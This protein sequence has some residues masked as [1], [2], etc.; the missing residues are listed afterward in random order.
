[1]AKT[2]VTKRETRK[3]ELAEQSVVETTE[4]VEPS[5]T[6][7]TVS[8]N[9]SLGEIATKYRLSLNRLLRLNDLSSS[10]IEIGTK[11]VVE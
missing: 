7:H 10:D 2:E 9:E 1:M 11:L 5:K 3:K 8:E 6:T 4:K